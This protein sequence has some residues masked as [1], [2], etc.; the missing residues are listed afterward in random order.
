M[1]PLSFDVAVAIGRFR[2]LI[3]EKIDDRKKCVSFIEEH[4]YC[5]PREANL[6]Y[7]YFKE[8]KDFSEIPSD[9]MLV[10][11]KFKSDKEYLLFHS[12]YGRRVNDAL[13]RAYGYAAARLRMRD[14]ELGIND[15]GFYIAGKKLDAEKIL[16]L[17]LLLE[18]Y[19]KYV[20]Q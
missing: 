4:I 14:I 2:K 1:L 12:M 17:N 15:N 8:Q 20:L 11:E 16:K 7:D 18:A 13:S 6:I 3:S 10:V 19:N 9:K 5:K